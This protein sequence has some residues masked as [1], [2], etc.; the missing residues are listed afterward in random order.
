M[1]YI[2]RN[3]RRP[4]PQR[5]FIRSRYLNSRKRLINLFLHSNS[6]QTTLAKQNVVYI[7]DTTNI[8][9]NKQIVSEN[10]RL[11]YFCRKKIL[12]GVTANRLV[13]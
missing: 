1:Q 7:T 2:H 10:D 4:V 3:M 11:L 8:D 9:N 5:Y 6:N 13:S 12:V